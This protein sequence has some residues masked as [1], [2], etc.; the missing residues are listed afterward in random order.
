MAVTNRDRIGRAMDVFAQGLAPFVERQMDARAQKDWRRWVDGELTRRFERNRDGGVHWDSQALLKVMVD[1]WRDVFAKTLGHAERALVG[2]LIEVRN[3]WAHQRPF[4]YDDTHRALDTGERLLNAVSAGAQ[5][6]EL[7]RMRQEV[8]RTMYAEQARGQTRRQ[9]LQLE[10]TPQAGLKPWREVTTPHPDLA[11]GRY[12]EAEFAADLAQVQRG[13]EDVPAEYGDPV[14]FFRRTFLTDGLSGLLESALRRLCGQPGGDPVIELQTNFG[15][16]K[17][18]SMLALYHLAGHPDPKTLL[19]VDQ[20]M[21]RLGLSGLDGVQ[22]AVL[23]GTAQSPGEIR[24]HNGGPET[25]TLWGELAWQLLGADGYRMV[26]S[27]DRSGLSPGSDL[28]HDLLATAA[29]CLILIDEWVAFIR[30]LYGASGQ[31]AGSFESNI[32]FAQALTEAVK[33]TPRALLVASLPQSRIEIGGEGGDRALDLLK[34]TFGRVES[35]WRP[36]STEEGFEI[37]RRRL[38]EPITEREASPPGTPWSGPSTAST[39]RTAPPSRPSAARPSTAAGS[40]L[41]T[42]STPSCSTAS[43][44]TGAPST[45]SSAPVGCCA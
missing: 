37:V 31:P 5:A 42:R 40:R 43:T 19:G 33:A 26:E 10:A 21:G 45:G 39:A 32:T 8:M 23:V 1:N 12:L 15:G 14:H 24:A 27:S 11:S 28:L 20:V 38:F 29:P 4:S 30:Q 9:T 17:T 25:R 34:N 6:A 7:G 36:A 18:H 41:P 2:E 3:R 16:G 44:T 35:S 13:G 22:R